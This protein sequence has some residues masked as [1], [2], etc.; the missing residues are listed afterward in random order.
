MY[1]GG[2]YGDPLE[3]DPEA[4][5]RDV[6]SL[7]VSG[8]IAEHVYGVAMSPDGEVDEGATKALRER[9]LQGRLERAV[10][11]R[12]YA[13]PDGNF[14]K[15]VDV[16]ERLAIG[17]VDGSDD[18]VFAC[19]GCGS[20]LCD[21]REN[22]KDWSGRIDSSLPEIDPVTFTDPAIEVDA[23]VVYRLFV[24]PSCGV[25]FENELTLRSDAPFRDITIDLATLQRPT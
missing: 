8:R 21:A 10:V 16:A 6:R 19:T 17:R 4:V 22:Y 3:R 15:W 24:C 2:G 1:G 14:A 11:E 25:S 20:L 13:G 9:L 18:F 5:A 23:D 12:R 7:L